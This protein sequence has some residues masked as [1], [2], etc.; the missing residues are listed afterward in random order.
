M[1][2]VPCPVKP[3]CPLRKSLATLSAGLL[4]LPPDQTGQAGREGSRYRM[5]AL[6]ETLELPGTPPIRVMIRRSAQAR[7]MS[8]RVSGL[9]GRV[10]L[11]VPRALSHAEA[12]GFVSEKR[13]WL[14]QALARVPAHTTIGPG[15]EIPFRGS[16][17]RIVEGES[18]ALRIAEDRLLVPHDPDGSRTR[19]RVAAFLK[20]HARAALG[21]A[22]HRHAR[23]LERSI[24]AIALRDTRS[25][26]G[27][28]TAQGRLM[29]SW[30][31]IMAPPC[32][33][34]YVAAHEVAHLRHM[35][36]SPAFWACVESLDPDWRSHRNWLREHGA[37]LHAFA[38]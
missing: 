9:D 28:C 3:H 26:W 2:Q 8:L 17:V 16:P 7:R 21:S 4:P 33:L 6:P 19:P 25:R 14:R 5:K 12:V 27:S 11:S 38:F 32:V 18:R 34:D 35:D 23:T 13:D 24:A 15:S 37:R 10:T 29:F 1:P 30:R 20:E 31:L 22:A 36:H